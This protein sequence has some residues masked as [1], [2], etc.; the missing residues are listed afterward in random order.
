MI[1]KYA[2]NKLFTSMVEVGCTGNVLWKTSA[3][4]PG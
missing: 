3:P 1:G 2:T 4:I